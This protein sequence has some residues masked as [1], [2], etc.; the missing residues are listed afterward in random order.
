MRDDV[1]WDCDLLVVGGGLA[2]S[3]LA[4]VMGRAGASVVVAER[5]RAFRDRIRGEVLHPWGVA[6]AYALDLA[7]PLLRDCAREMPMLTSH[8][9]GVAGADARHAHDRAS[10]PPVDDI[11]A[12]CDAGNAP[13]G[14]RAGRDHLAR[15]E[16]DEPRARTCAVR[17]GVR[18]RRIASRA[19]TTRG[20]RGRP[21]IEGR[22]RAGSSAWA[23]PRGSHHVR[24]AR[25]MRRSSVRFRARPP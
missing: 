11:S 14:G 19:G 2:G 9:G 5:E 18:E 22:E 23:R 1:E 4:A 12:P 17:D 21:R 7:E 6:E 8:V 20:R 15:L 13:R 3:A 25:R 10:S 24:H 16:H